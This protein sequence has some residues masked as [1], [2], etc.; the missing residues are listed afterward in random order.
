MEYK[1]RLQEGGNYF[2]IIEHENEFNKIE[3]IELSIGVKKD[4][5]DA[6]VHL[7]K[8]ELH[9]LIGTL[10]HVQAKMK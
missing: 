5:S 7:S 1:M 2:G 8:T 4:F 3:L 6:H 10:L 9:K